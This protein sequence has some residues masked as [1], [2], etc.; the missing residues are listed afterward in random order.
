MTAAFGVGQIVGPLMAGALATGTGGYG[1]ASLAAAV[2]LALAAIAT[3][4]AGRAS[5]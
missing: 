1:A 2:L 4:P 5:H 3:F